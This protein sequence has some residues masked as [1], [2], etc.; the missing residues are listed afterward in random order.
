[1]LEVID[2]QSVEMHGADSSAHARNPALLGLAC[3]HCHAKYPLRL[4][5]SGCSAC[6]LQGLYVSLAADYL[7]SPMKATYLPYEIGFSL[8]EGQTPLIEK[9]LLAKNLGIG[10]LHIKDESANPTGSHKDRMSAVGIT[11]AIDFGA[12]T[13][14]LASSGNAAISAAR[15]AQAAGLA[16]DVATY[17]DMPAAYADE[18]DTYGAKRFAFEDNAGRWDFV[19][20]RAL[21]P[22]YFALTNYHL[23]ALG[24]APLAIEG[25]KGIAYECH[26]DGYLPE[27]IM[28]PTARGD[29]AWGIYAGYRDLLNA[30]AIKTL[31]KIWIVEPF[32]RLTSVVAG[33]GLHQ[34]YAG[35][36]AQ[37][38]TAG[39]TVTYLQYQAATASG[40]GALIVPDAHARAART[41]LARHGISAELCAAAGFAAIEQLC[42]LHVATADSKVMLVLTANA[43]RDPS[44]PDSL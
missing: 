3:L 33:H 8:G 10:Q 38:S 32:A 9:N 24:S 37:F 13:V 41:L 4:V 26:A 12:H 16:C 11:Q 39:A 25:Y 31:P 23:P 27:H 14:V 42:A 43:S 2:N 40:G 15:Y 36:T 34:N 6:S 22:G 30:G 29:L 19:A 18:L 35:Q 21:L 28:V 1:M 7:R 5:H 17:A 44:Y 20:E